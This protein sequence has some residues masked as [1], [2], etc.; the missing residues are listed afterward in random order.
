MLGNAGRQRLV[1]E[2][3]DHP[4]ALDYLGEF[5]DGKSRH[6]ARPTVIARAAVSVPVR[7]SILNR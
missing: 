3:A 1:R 2:R 7:S 4:A 5:H 6:A